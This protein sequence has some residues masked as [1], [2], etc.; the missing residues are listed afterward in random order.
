MWT[1]PTLWDLGCQTGAT[2]P[3]M[4]WAFFAQSAFICLGTMTAGPLVSTFDAHPVLLACATLVAATLV[5]VPACA[6][7]T[8]LAIVLLPFPF[9]PL[10][11]TPTLAGRTWP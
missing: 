4:T 5:A 3:T 9:P 1:G 6:S 2:R 8:S 11:H 7:I 10:S